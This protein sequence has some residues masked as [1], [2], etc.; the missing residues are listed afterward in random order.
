M[1]ADPHTSDEAHQWAKERVQ[2]PAL[3]L[4]ANGALNLLVALFQSGLFV[5]TVLTPP[6]T[7][8]RLWIERLEPSG[9]VDSPLAQQMREMARQAREANPIQFKRQRLAFDGSLAAILLTVSLLGIAGGVRMY[10][11]RTFPLAMTGALASLIPCVSPM[12]C[13][14]LGEL[15]GGWCVI[16]LLLPGVRSAF[17]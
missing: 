6:E 5:M 9:K 3:F 2:M 12:S 14:C 13:C 1:T 17:R 10:Q 4:T 15:I 11:A 7:V 8:Q 16:V